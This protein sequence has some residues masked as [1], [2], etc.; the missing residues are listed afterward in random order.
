MSV[1]K[2][3]IARIL[4]ISGFLFHLGNY[5]MELFNFYNGD[6]D[7]IVHIIDDTEEKSESKEKDSSEKEDLKEK[8]KI[9]QYA[10]EKSTKIAILTLRDF[11]ELNYGNSSVYLDYNTPPPEYL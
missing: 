6:I 1:I 9:S 5:A 4:I 3:N 2:I 7:S 8:D 10:D 11:P